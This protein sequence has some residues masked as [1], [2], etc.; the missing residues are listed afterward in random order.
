MSKQEETCS[1]QRRAIREGI[2]NILTQVYLDGQNGRL[3]YRH[4]DL[5]AFLHD[6]DVVIKVEDKKLN[7]GET[8]IAYL[9]EPL[10]KEE[11]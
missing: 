10:I 8:Y 5:L 6:N 7:A 9:V 2:A 4:D 3:V 1:E 11:K